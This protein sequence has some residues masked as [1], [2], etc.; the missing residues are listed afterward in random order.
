[1]IADPLIR[2]RIRPIRIIRSVVP[3]RNRLGSLLVGVHSALFPAMPGH[4]ALSF[5]YL[6]VQINFLGS[7]NN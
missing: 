1:M 7:L 5:G 2:P 6:L 3:G 4:A